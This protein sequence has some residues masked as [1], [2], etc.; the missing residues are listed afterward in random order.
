L[1]IVLKF[2]KGKFM[3]LA[4]VPINIWMGQLFSHKEE[5]KYVICRKMCGP[6]CYYV[7]EIRERKKGKYQVSVICG[8]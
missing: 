4:Y 7:S 3:D 6:G 5:W 1:F 2:T 8:V